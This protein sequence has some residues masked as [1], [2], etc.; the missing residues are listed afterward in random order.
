MA[1]NI[2]TLRVEKGQEKAHTLHEWQIAPLGNSPPG[3][4]RVSGAAGRRVRSR[5]HHTHPG[6]TA[7]AQIAALDAEQI[8]DDPFAENLKA[9]GF[10]SIVSGLQ[11]DHVAA[12]KPTLLL[13]QG[14]VLLLLLIGSVNLVNLLLI[15]APGPA[16][17]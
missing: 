6:A 15:R 5:W 9:M 13:L 2:S 10:V 3:P 8:K 7:R 16:R 12:I 11:E 4:H 1:R 14:G 17:E